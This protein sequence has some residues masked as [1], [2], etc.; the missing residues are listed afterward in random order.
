[1]RSQKG[2]IL[3]WIIFI[4]IIV[5]AFALLV[6]Y[7]QT[8][9]PPSAP[10]I[11]PEEEAERKLPKGFAIPE[12]SEEEKE[13]LD[14]E[15]FRKAMQSGEG[16]EEIKYDEELKQVCLDTLLFNSALQKNDEKLCEKIVD[17]D[18]K[19]DCFDHVYSNLAIKTFDA[20]LCKKI[21]DAE[22][23]QNCLDRIQASLGRTAA[24]AETCKSIQDQTL[25]QKCLDNFYFSNS[26]D[27]L[28]QESCENIL[29]VELKERC[30]KTI[31][32]NIE[33]IELSEKQAVPEYQSSEEKLQSCDELSGENADLCRNEANY[34]LAFEKKDLSYCNA[35]T[36]S[37]T[38]NQCIKTQ[39]INING[40]YFRQAT[41][42]KDPNLCNKILDE[43]LR[44][45]CLTYAQ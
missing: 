21:S 40:Y 41:Y 5:I 45:T 18:L 15:E 6:F 43:G 33:V 36:D 3:S 8:R 17:K 22:L 20:D 30:T 31:V 32:K 14:S 9:R 16:C 44:S 35:I 37:E 42:K 25:K 28:N 19:T 29:D 11:T 4:V 2:K 34:N 39:S 7:Q 12:L 26:I 23:K 13:I 38:Q 10:P 24:S 27:N 1:M